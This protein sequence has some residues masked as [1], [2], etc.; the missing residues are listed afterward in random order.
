M[1]LLERCFDVSAQLAVPVELEL[2]GNTTATIDA[3]VILQLDLADDEFGRIDIT[4]D[5]SSLI[6]VPGIRPNPNERI[7]VVFAHAEKKRKN[8][9]I[10]SR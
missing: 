4:E 3:M 10:R 8:E 7:S 6:R 1:G 2:V 5:T 9:K